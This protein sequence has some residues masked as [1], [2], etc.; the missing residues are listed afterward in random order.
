MATIEQLRSK[1][2]DRAESLNPWIVW[3]KEERLQAS[4]HF[5]FIGSDSDPSHVADLA[6]KFGPNRGQT[7]RQ[8]ATSQR[9]Y[10]RELHQKVLL[11]A[12]ITAKFKSLVEMVLG[13]TA[14]EVSA[15]HSALDK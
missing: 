7:L 14:K 6:L 13:E 3:T 8:L 11:S 10:L 5:A 12:A 2:K 15:K 9:P 1:F 4:S